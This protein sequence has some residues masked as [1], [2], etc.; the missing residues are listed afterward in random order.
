MVKPGFPAICLS[1][2]DQ[3]AVKTEKEEEPVTE[4]TSK[5]APL[6]DT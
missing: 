4:L 2:D 3:L 6:S 1:I 5:T